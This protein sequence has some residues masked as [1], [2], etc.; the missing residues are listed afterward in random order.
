[1]SILMKDLVDWRKSTTGTGVVVDG[2][3]GVSFKATTTTA[4]DNAEHY[5][6]FLVRAI[7]KIKVS[8]MARITTASTNGVNPVAQLYLTGSNELNRVSVSGTSWQL[9]TMETTAP[10]FKDTPTVKELVLHLGSLVGSTGG[11]EF[12]DV[13]ID[14]LDDDIHTPRMVAIGA[15]NFNAGAVSIRTS[16][17]NKGIKSI[18]WDATYRNIEVDIGILGVNARPFATAVIGSEGSD[19][20][21]GGIQN[22]LL[23][24]FG[25]YNSSTGK[26]MLFFQE[27]GTPTGK[28]D[29]VA[30]AS[31]FTTNIMIMI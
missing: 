25:D 19:T 8:F 7:S 12:R 20:S 29:L 14:I 13:R 1:M 3:D 2:A 31:V 27:M 15:I 23:P 10:S 16:V 5:E 24:Y 4:G 26:I 18:A 21:V 30:K 28:V 11:A 6:S 22:N 9:Y 17:V